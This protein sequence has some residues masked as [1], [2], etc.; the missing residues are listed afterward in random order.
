MF[1]T[2]FAI[3]E[4]ESLRVNLPPRGSPE[5]KVAIDSRLFLPNKTEGGGAREIVTTECLLPPAWGAGAELKVAK[6]AASRGETPFP[7]SPPCSD[8]RLT[9]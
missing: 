9:Y 2:Y 5:G 3:L 4:E 1:Q 8:K 6:K 7:V